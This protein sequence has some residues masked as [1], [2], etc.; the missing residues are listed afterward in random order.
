MNLVVS[1]TV[2]KRH[3]LC[4]M[5]AQGEAMR[6]KHLSEDLWSNF[7]MSVMIKVLEKTL[8][9]KSIFPNNF[10]ELTNNIRNGLSFLLSWLSSTVVCE[11]SR[12]V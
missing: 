2:H 5:L 4:L 1:V 10:L 6:S 8:R 12:I 3:K 7:E 9:I 11:C